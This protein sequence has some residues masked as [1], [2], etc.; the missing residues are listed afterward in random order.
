MSSPYS[1]SAWPMPATLPCP[2]M[3]KQP[4]KK[5]VSAPS[6]ST[7]W[8]ARKRTSAWAIVNRTVIW[9]PPLSL[10]SP[11]VPAC[12]LPLQLPSHVLEALA[13]LDDRALALGRLGLHHRVLLQHV[14]APVARAF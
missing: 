11:L 2:K 8:F 1:K 13:H 4:A 3:P 14:P 12:V 7:Y 5:D 10:W 9:P 6:R